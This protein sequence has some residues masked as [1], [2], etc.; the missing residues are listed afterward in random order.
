MDYHAA[1]KDL[2]MP[3]NGK[4]YFV[5]SCPLF[6]FS[7]LSNGNFPTTTLPKR[8]CFTPV[9][10]RT[11]LGLLLAICL[12]SNNSE[13]FLCQPQNK[14]PSRCLEHAVSLLFYM[15]PCGGK[16]RKRLSWMRLLAQLQLFFPCL[17]CYPTT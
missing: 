16:T 3:W 2:Y 7:K 8:T 15:F 6:E 9:V 14:C 17:S 10:L 12:L 1:L 11:C 4:L 5:V 13:N